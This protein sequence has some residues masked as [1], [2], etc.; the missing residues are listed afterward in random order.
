MDAEIRQE[1]S[2]RL[3]VALDQDSRQAIYEAPWWNEGAEEFDITD[4]IT[5]ITDISPRLPA[6]NIF[7]II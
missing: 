3:V 7:K 1:A 5:D 4:I 2:S 6:P